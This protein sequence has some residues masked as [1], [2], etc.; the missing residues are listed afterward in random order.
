MTLN[1]PEH[2]E[3]T[4]GAQRIEIMLT[5]GT[6]VTL[7]PVFQHSEPCRYHRAVKLP[8]RTVVV[9]VR[10]LVRQLGEDLAA[11]AARDVPGIL[12]FTLRHHFTTAELLLRQI[13]LHG[14]ALHP[15]KEATP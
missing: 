15:E 8:T 4:V 1:R 13:F 5:D 7:H 10:H 2:H 9:D 12:F 3:F 11:A 14:S 6:A